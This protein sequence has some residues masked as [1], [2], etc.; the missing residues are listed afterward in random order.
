M[1]SDFMFWP[2]AR[3]V[4]AEG[5]QPLVGRV[6]LLD[7]AGA[8]VG[9]E[10]IAVGIDRDASGFSR[11]ARRRPCRRSARGTCRRSYRTPA[12][13][14]GTHRWPAA[15]RP[16]EGEI[17]D[18]LEL[19][20]ADPFRAD[21]HHVLESQGGGGR[22]AALSSGPTRRR[23]RAQPACTGTSMRIFLV[24]A[25][26]AVNLK[27]GSGC[28]GRFDRVAAASGRAGIPVQSLL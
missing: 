11:L 26:G 13:R 3:A 15:G 8:V 23:A 6:V 16:A 7:E 25:V 21:V 1:N 22:L 27:F 28:L 9:N 14:L 24:R 20:F 4:L 12:P 2:G 5:Q 18:V 17:L 10:D 19:A